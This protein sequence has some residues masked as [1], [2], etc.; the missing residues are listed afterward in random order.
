M[1]VVHFSTVDFAGAYRAAERISQSLKHVGVDSRVVVRSKTKPDTDAIPY[2]NNPVSG[3]ISKV[4]NAGNLILSSGPVGTDLFGTDISGSQFV[5]DADVIFIHWVNSFI[6]FEGINKLASTG[7]RIIW[8]MHDMWPFTGGCHLN[9]GCDEFS[10]ECHNCPQITN[11]SKSDIAARNLIKKKTAYAHDN[12]SFVTVSN[13]MKDTADKSAILSD[14]NVFMIHN[15]INTEIFNPGTDSITGTSADDAKKTILFGAYGTTTDENKGFRYLTDAL[16]KL[17]G[18]KYRAVCFGNSP[19][20][21]PIHLDN[22]DIKYVGVVN[23]DS[24]LIDLYRKADVTVVP[25]LMESFGYTCL[26]SMACGTPVVAFDTTGLRD[27]II[28]TDNGYLA[29]YKD[30]DDFSDGIR[31]CCDRSAELGINARKT[32][33]DNCS[34]DVIGNQYLGLCNG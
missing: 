23:D 16:R 14:H 31:F 29:R 25:S 13:W 12:I 18:S 3:I 21:H 9:F 11:R 24:I 5:R 10:K 32:A 1:K 28:H 6:S 2:F 7:K 26:E 17:D 15:P 34:Y 20:D 8:V 30:T 22:I 27:Q 4:K 19:D 33:V